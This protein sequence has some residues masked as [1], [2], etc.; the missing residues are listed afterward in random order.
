MSQTSVTILGSGTCVP[1]LQRSSCA[2]LVETGASRLLFD[3]GP[4]T[5]HRL[6]ST[7]ISL[8]DIDFIFYSHFHPDHSG[9]LV[10]FIFATKYPDSSRRRTPLTMAGGYGFHRFINGLKAVYGDWMSLP[11]GMLRLVELEKEGPARRQFTSFSVETMPMNH[12]EESLGYRITDSG[13]RSIVYSGDTDTT[14]NLVSLATGADLLVCESAMPDELKVPGHLTPSLAGDLATRAHVK[15]LVLTHLYPECDQV[16]LKAQCRR[17]YQGPP[18]HRTGFDEDRNLKYYPVF[19]DIKGR[20]CLVVGGGDVGTR[21]AEMLL[22]CQASVTVISLEITEAMQKL[23]E[24]QRITLVR[25]AYMAS[26][27]DNRF[28]VIGATNDEGLNQQISTEAE[29]RNLLCNIADRPAACNFILPAIVR[30][31]DLVM[32]ISTSGKSPAFAKKLRQD[33][34]LQFG[35]AYAVFLELMGAI[36][37]RLLLEQHAPEQHKPLFHKIIHSDILLWIENH[38]SEKINALLFEVLGPGYV[39]DELL[40]PKCPH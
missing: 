39:M 26:D 18:A 3:S 28:L 40:N 23:A 25:R 35:K 31:G 7:G 27:L 29:K 20:N 36:R 38:Q 21:K 19:L 12:R 10:P 16:D 22:E 11:E 2:I 30:Q 5:M 24:N 17:T 34:E 15:K 14:Q 33:L 6:L 1:S 32:A 8:F 4:G 13:G 37:C 9:E